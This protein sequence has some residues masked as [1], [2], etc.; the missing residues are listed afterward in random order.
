MTTD[1]E[2]QLETLQ[3]QMIKYNLQIAAL[4]QLIVDVEEKKAATLE[5]IKNIQEQG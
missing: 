2:K 1:N 3:M 5:K 4:N